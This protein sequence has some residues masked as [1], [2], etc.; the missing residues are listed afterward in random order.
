MIGSYKGDVEA[1]YAGT[2]GLIAY[3]SLILLTVWVVLFPKS[4]LVWRLF[5]DLPFPPD[6]LKKD[7]NFPD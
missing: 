4:D 5:K 3:F 6:I 7:L 2:Q 1:W